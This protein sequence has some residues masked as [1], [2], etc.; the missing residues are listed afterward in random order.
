MQRGFGLLVVAMLAGSAG[1]A[2]A[3][4]TI[5]GR[6]A[7]LRVST[8][9]AGLAP[10]PVVDATSNFDIK[11][12]KDTKVTAQINSPMPAGVTLAI[13]LDAPGTA[14]SIPEV[15]LDLT[16]RDVLTGFAGMKGTSKGLSITYKL[17]ATPAA[18][19]VPLQSRT[20]TL[21][22]VNAP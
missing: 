16:A 5:H 11:L 2:A 10:D 7:T 9:T 20:V 6:P 18:G 1:I 14:V 13:T 3:Q 17:T 15:P 21:T 12:D 4:V 19:V 8:A 22:L